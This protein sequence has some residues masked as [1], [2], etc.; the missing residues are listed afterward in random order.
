[1]ISTYLYCFLDF[2]SN[3][4][5]DYASPAG[6]PEVNTDMMGFASN[7]DRWYWVL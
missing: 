2:R 7:D 5:Y 1:M 3:Y 4:I 6:I